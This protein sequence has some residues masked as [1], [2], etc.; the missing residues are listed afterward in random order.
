MSKILIVDNDEAMRGLLRN[1]LESSYE[2]VDTGDPA[3]VL[4][5]AIAHKPDAVLLDLMVPK[6]SGV[7]LCQKLHSLRDTSGIKVFIVTGKDGGAAQEYCKSLGATAFFHKPLDFNSLK[8][9]LAESLGMPR[10]ECRTELRVPMR[11]SL[12]LRGTDSFG[13]PFEEL[14]ATDNVSAHGFLCSCTASLASGDLVEVFLAGGGNE[15][16]V[17]RARV[18]RK[19]TDLSRQRYGFYLEEKKGEWVLQA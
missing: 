12:K 9:R 19:E 8:R 6:L 3:Q 4:E 18:A 5:L 15:R 1:R 10:P 7:D 11:V 13:A 2:V 14:T 16:Y 17:G